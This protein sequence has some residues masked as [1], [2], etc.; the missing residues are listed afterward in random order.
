MIA[1]HRQKLTSL[2]KKHKPKLLHVAKTIARIVIIIIL[3][4]FGVKVLEHI[5][6]FLRFGRTGEMV[7]GSV[8]D[9]LLVG[10]WEP[11]SEE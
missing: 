3:I 8:A 6:V 7:T 2:T 11:T 4:H 9:Y 5:G 1:S 10:S